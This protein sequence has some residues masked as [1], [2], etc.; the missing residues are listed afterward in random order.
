MVHVQDEC[1]LV[2]A[3]SVSTPVAQLPADHL[4][5]LLAPAV[6][7]HRPPV[8]VVEDLHP[9]LPGTVSSNQTH[10]PI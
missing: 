8:A 10:H 2:F 9:T 3:Q 4:C 1:S 5:M 7:A 6:V